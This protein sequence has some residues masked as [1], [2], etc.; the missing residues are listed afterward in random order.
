[1]P[2]VILTYSRADRR[3][4]KALAAILRAHKYSIWE[5]SALLPIELR[6]SVLKAIVSESSCMVVLWSSTSIYDPDVYADYE[7]GREQNIVYCAQIGEPELP[8]TVI[9]R[10]AGPHRDD[11]SA[12]IGLIEASLQQCGLNRIAEVDS[13][14]SSEVML[15]ENGRYS[16]DR[17]R[18]ARKPGF[19][20]SRDSFRL[21]QQIF[22]STAQTLC[23][24]IISIAL[25]LSLVF[26]GRE[27]A[28]KIVR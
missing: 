22:F 15:L 6:T 27:I 18:S 5:H 11:L 26:M 21:Q 3:H 23:T 19:D 2:T 10:Q 25:I 13:T 24:S 4:A 28:S 17:I 12:I 14:P 20:Q 16:T 1:M 8:Q 7:L 9:E